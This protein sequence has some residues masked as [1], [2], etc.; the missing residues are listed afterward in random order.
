MNE[1]QKTAGYKVVPV[2]PTAEM[3]DKCEH[4]HQGCTD[5]IQRDKQNAKATP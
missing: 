3:R 2:E 1:Q 4:G 5:I